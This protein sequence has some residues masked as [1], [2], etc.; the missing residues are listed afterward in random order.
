ML[1]LAGGLRKRHS[2]VIYL[3]RDHPPEYELRNF[4]FYL[5]TSALIGE[6]SDSVE[7]EIDD[8]LTNG[9]VTTGVVVGGILFTGDQLFGVEKLAVGTSSDLEENFIKPF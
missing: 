1:T 8:F 7:D 3:H 4:L 9:V 5:E 2:F 6:F